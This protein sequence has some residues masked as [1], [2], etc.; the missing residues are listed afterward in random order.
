MLKQKR[1]S[2]LPYQSS[3][4]SDFLVYIYTV[5]VLLKRNAKKLHSTILCCLQNQELKQPLIVCAA[6]FVGEANSKGAVM[7]P[8]WSPPQPL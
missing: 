2:L 6:D 8:I 4:Q 5:L 7:L 1:D 3:I